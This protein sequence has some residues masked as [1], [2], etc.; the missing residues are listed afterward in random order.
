MKLLREVVGTPYYIAPEVLKT[1]YTEKCDIWSIGVI[2]FMM[3]TGYPPYDGSNE[4]EVMRSIKSGKSNMHLLN[5]ANITEEAKDLLS[6]LLM[7]NPNH[8]VTSDKALNHKWIKFH[9]KSDQNNEVTKK[10]LIALSQYNTSAKLQEAVITF[11][12]G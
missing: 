6:Q 4:I 12:V 9:D 1:S 5:F 8:R 3:L 11:V 2:M 7:I 10:A